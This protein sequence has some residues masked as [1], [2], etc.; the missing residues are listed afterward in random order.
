[1]GIDGFSLLLN[2]TVMSPFLGFKG[3]WAN[4][5][6]DMTVPPPDACNYFLFHLAIST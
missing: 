3:E 6:K 4:Y 1:M 5:R 2:L